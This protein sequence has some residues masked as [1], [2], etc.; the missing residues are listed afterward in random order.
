MFSC[1]YRL[2]CCSSTFR[3][4]C[5]VESLHSG[6]YVYI[7]C[8]T[9]YPR[10]AKLAVYIVPSCVYLCMCHKSEFHHNDRRAEAVF[11]HIDYAWLTR[12]CVT[13]EIRCLQTLRVLPSCTLSQTL[14]LADL[15]AFS[16]Q[17][18]DRRKCCQLS[19][20]VDRRRFITMSIYVHDSYISYKSRQL[21]HS[22]MENTILKGMQ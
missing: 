20:A 7:S 5:R 17:N 12:H 15:P 10:D 1:V 13:S 14:N 8:V 22:C 6:N 18:V 4:Y 19:S 2:S 21:L 9:F 11:W 16:P 3:L